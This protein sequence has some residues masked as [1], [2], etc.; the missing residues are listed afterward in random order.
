MRAFRAF[1]V[2]AAILV[3]TA[4]PASAAAERFTDDLTGEVFSCSGHTYTLQGEISGVFH[5]FLDAQGRHHF[6]LVSTTSSVTA[7]DENGVLYN[8]TGAEAFHQ[9]QTTFGTVGHLTLEHN[10]VVR[11][12]GVVDQ[13]RVVEQHLAPGE[14]TTHFTTTCFDIV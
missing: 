5:F 14:P 2:A 11:G 6:T 8:F 7:T 1:V 13:I 3:A 12:E 10:F 4:T 9:Q